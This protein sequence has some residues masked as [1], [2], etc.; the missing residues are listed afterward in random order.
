M[1]TSGVR[2][3]SLF[4]FRVHNTMLSPWLASQLLQWLS[5]PFESFTS[6]LTVPHTF[7]FLHLKENLG[8]GWNTETL[9]FLQRINLLYQSFSSD[10]C[11]LPPPHIKNCFK[12]K[13]EIPQGQFAILFSSG[14]IENA[15]F[16]ESCVCEPQTSILPVI[17][18]PIPRTSCCFYLFLPA[19]CFLNYFIQCSI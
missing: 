7:H 4:S 1:L 14:R 15:V 2:I 16:F 9:S 12:G 13:K 17:F 19:R 6:F 10:L 3:W 18:F 5:R 11:V 8:V